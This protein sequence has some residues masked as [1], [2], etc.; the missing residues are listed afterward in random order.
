MISIQD[1]DWDDDLLDA[2]KRDG[3]PRARVYRPSHVAVVLGRGSKPETE[4]NIEAAQRDSIPLLRRRGGGCSV[5]LDTGNIIVSCALPLPGVG[6]TTRAFRTISNW[7]IDALDQT[8]V[9]HVRQAGISDLA[10]GE[11]K[12]GGACIYRTKGLLYYTTTLLFQPDLDLVERYLIHPPREPDYRAGRKHSAFMGSLA[13]SLPFH[14]LS[15]FAQRI[16]Q[17]LVGTVETLLDVNSPLNGQ[18]VFKTTR[19]KAMA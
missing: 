2:T 12:I 6:G 16:N 18:S 14:D 10:L 13:N 19:Q 7:V 4:I 3:R 1:F 5:V 8:G 17:V 11:R 9:P 15:S